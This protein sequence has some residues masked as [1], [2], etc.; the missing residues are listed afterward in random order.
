MS[1]QGI[2]ERTAHHRKVWVLGGIAALLVVAVFLYGLVNMIGAGVRWATAGDPPP[3]VLEQ[4][5]AQDNDASLV[6]LFAKYC[7]K[8]WARST[9]ETQG[10]LS[11]CFTVPPEARSASQVAAEVT[12]VDAY[13]PQ[14]VY[15]DAKVSLWSVLVA[16]TVKEFADDRPTRQ[17]MPL[18]VSLAA[19]GG[20]RAML[21]PRI[22]ATTLPPGVDME[23]A[24]P[25][26]VRGVDHDDAATGASQG[27]G[28]SAANS[29]LYEVVKGFMSAYLV[30]PASDV[31]RFAA[32]ESGLTGLGRLYAEVSIDNM[33]SDVP[34]DGAPLPGEQAHV[35]VTVTGT[36]ASGGVKTMQYPLLVGD[37]EG[38]WVVQALDSVPATTGRMLPTGR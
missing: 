20:P 14:E 13:Q 15:R 10:A 2:W 35:L 33:L 23:L 3:P 5:A 26:T 30:G 25:H 34:A 19:G 22:E 1:M 12:D 28:A 4:V 38:R 36:K 16:A 6:A 9:P 18:S 24:Y 21:L 8:L 11:E 32:A 7:V 31:D 17:Y 29:P 37:S 27:Q